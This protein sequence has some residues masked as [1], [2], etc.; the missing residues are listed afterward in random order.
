MRTETKESALARLAKVIHLSFEDDRPGTFEDWR[1]IVVEALD[2]IN[3]KT[4][5]DWLRIAKV[6]RL[7]VVQEGTANVGRRKFRT[8]IWR[9]G[10]EFEKYLSI[11]REDEV[12]EV[13][14]VKPIQGGE[15]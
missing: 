10:P 12:G 5:T 6:S 9:K 4:A 15:Q 7:I 11:N 3:E 8:H 2:R 13:V 14:I 1:D